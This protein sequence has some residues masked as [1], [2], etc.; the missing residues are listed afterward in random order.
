MRSNTTRELERRH[1]TENHTDHFDQVGTRHVV[2]SDW[3]YGPLSPMRVLASL[4]E[5]MALKDAIVGYTS[6]GAYASLD[7]QRKGTLKKGMLA[8]IVVLSKDILKLPRTELPTVSVTYT[9][10]DGRLVYPVS[11]ET[12]FP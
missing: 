9:I 3:P 8:D 2:G 11:K 1:R 7:E 6:A 10:F 4:P 12:T 5:S